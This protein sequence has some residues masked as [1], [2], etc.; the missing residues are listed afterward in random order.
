MATFQPAPIKAPITVDLLDQIDVRVGTIVKVE[1]VPGSDK[2]VRLSVDFGDHQRVILAG[3]KQERQDP[4]EIEGCQALFVVNLPPRKMAGIVS[5]GM[6]FDLGHADGIV[7]VLAVPE[8][9]IPNGSR[10]G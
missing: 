4:G 1:D 6:L 7:P 8:R 10:A 2:L 5:E 3:M 9:P